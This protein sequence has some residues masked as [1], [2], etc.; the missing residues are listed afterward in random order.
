M[1]RVGINQ[2]VGNEKIAKDICLGNGTI[3]LPAGSIL[4]KDYIKYLISLSIMHVYIEDTVDIKVD[5][6]TEELIQEQCKQIVKTTIEKYSYCG[7]AELKNI[8]KAADNI[9]QDIIKQ[10]E[11][12]YNI[13]CVREK[14][15]SSYAHSINVA[16]LSV[17]VAL[18]MKLQESRVKD[19]AIGALLQDIGV[20]FIPFDCSNVILDEADEITKKE[21]RK[22][23]INGYTVV[24]NEKWISNVS[25]DIILSHHERD[26]GSGYPMHLTKEKIRFETKIVALCDQFDSLVYGYFCKK[27]KVHEAIDYILSNSGTKFNQKIVKKFIES[28]AAYPIGTYVVTNEKEIGIVIRQNDKIPT[29]PVIQMIQ[30]SNGEKYTTVVEKDLTKE[31]TLFIRDTLPGC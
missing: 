31:L 15:E 10:P 21:I 4:K 29:R 22:H 16:A 24:E 14:S 30:D 25:K 20:M 12:L 8:I 28:V 6:A 11:I 13:S 3:L 19:I 18:R 5:V 7:S 9:L 17:L 1:K 23:V 2:I 26:D 27:L